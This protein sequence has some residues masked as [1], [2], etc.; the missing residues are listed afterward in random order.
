MTEEEELP[1]LTVVEPVMSN[2]YFHTGAG[3]RHLRRA[4][5]DLITERLRGNIYVLLGS[6]ANIIVLS[7]EHGKFLVDSGNSASTTKVKAALKEISPAPLKYMWSALIGTGITLMAIDGCTNLEQ[8]SLHTGGGVPGH[9]EKKKWR[10]LPVGEVHDQPAALAG[11]HRRN[12]PW[13]RVSGM[14]GERRSLSPSR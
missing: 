8:P 1:G 5:G 7:G 3:A 4:E 12:A 6:G 11:G 9:V 10:I 2:D 13:A 14:V